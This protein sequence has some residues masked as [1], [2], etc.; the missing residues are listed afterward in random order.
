MRRVFKILSF[1]VVASIVVSV[2]ACLFIVMGYEQAFEE[3]I[4]GDTKTIVSQRFG[5]PSLIEPS[6]KPYLRYASVPCKAPCVERLWWEHPVL[7]GIEAWSVEF[8]ANGKVVDKAHWA[9]P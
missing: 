4:D 9:S 1:L 7:R 2:G 6:T 5:S 8:D 3:T